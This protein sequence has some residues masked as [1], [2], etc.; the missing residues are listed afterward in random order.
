MPKLF[1]HAYDLSYRIAWH[2]YVKIPLVIIAAALDK[3]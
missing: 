1:L 2:F 3:S